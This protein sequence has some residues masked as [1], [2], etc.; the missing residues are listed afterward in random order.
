LPVLIDTGSPRDTFRAQGFQGQVIMDIP[1]KDLVIVRLGLTPDADRGWAAVGDWL[2]R[3]ARA[4]SAGTARYFTLNVGNAPPFSMNVHFA[5]AQ[6]FS[7]ISMRFSCTYCS[8]ERPMA[9]R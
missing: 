2:G 5:S 4:F 7:S 6:T 8:G 3:V 1:S 9:C